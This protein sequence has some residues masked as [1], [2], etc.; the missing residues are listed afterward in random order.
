MN[1]KDKFHA[2]V[3]W[4]DCVFA[5]TDKKIVLSTSPFGKATHWKQ[6]IL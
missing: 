2:V 5:A 6:T 4:F 3:A 1:K